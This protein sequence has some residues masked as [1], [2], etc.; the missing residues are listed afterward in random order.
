MI[1][2]FCTQCTILILKKNEF[3]FTAFAKDLQT[4]QGVTQSP[5]IAK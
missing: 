4:S 1:I 3:I 2:T 5:Q